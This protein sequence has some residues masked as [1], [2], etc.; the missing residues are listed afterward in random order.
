MSE[1][2]DTDL[3]ARVFDGILLQ[4]GAEARKELGRQIAALLLDPDTRPG[5]REAVIPTLLRLAGDPVFEVRHFLAL[6]LREVTPLHPDI[7]FA[8]V[9]GDD[10]I[11]L[12]FIA[13]TPAMD[14]P[15]ML[16][17]LK[18]GDT[19]RRAQIAQ[20][21]DV[22][23]QC[24]AFIVAAAEWQVAAALLDNVAYE[25][26]R[27]EYRRL[28]TRLGGQPE[29]IE[30]LL[31]R[32]GL[33]LEI[34]ILESRRASRRIN[35][36]LDEA[37]LVTA[38]D[39]DEIVAD[40]EDSAMLRIMADADDGELDRVLPF[41]L[42]K[43]LLTPMLLLKAAAVGAMRLVDRVLAQLAGMPLRRVQALI[44]GRGA[45]SVRAV[46]NRSGLPETC[47][48]LLQAAV[49]VERQARREAQTLSSDDFGVRMVETI[50]TRYVRLA[51][52]DRSKLLDFMIR[53]GTE[54][55][56]AVAEKLKSGMSQA[57]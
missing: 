10:D 57:A 48:Q 27:D 21:P 8:I 46:F 11:A 15:R 20:R 36:F 16:A 28:F 49:E 4:G 13:A 55:A 23:P 5:E 39:P 51:P 50:M 14:A 33:P 37:G 54:E 3:D 22:S 6:C 56:R 2:N 30:R 1:D 9:A 44:Y 18:V 41:L 53:L 19:P 43:K 29:V 31:A 52:G 32:P 25:P 12:P 17:V 38:R 40:A 26:S 7:L 47:L 24:V 35:R 42:D 45:P 34:R